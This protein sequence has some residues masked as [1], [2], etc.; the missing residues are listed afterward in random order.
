MDGNVKDCGAPA[1][2]R[3]RRSHHKDQ[4]PAFC[5]CAKCKGIVKQ[6]PRTI[7]NHQ[8]RYPRRTPTPERIGSPAVLDQFEGDN[9][10]DNDRSLPRLNPLQLPLS[11]PQSPSRSDQS[12]GSP[13]E[14]LTHENMV[15]PV[16]RQPARVVTPI[17]AGEGMEQQ[18]PEIEAEE[19]RIYQF[20]NLFN[21]KPLN[22]NHLHAHEIVLD[23]RIMYNDQEEM[24]DHI[25][26]DYE[27]F[28]EDF[29]L[30][31]GGDQPPINIAPAFQLPEEDEPEYAPD[32]DP[33]DP[34]N[35]GA[36][37]PAFQE[38]AAIRNAYIDAFIQKNLY[39][40]T[41]RALKHQ[42][43]AIRRTVSSHPDVNIED[44]SRMAQSIGTVE[45]RLG[46]DTDNIIITFVLCPTCKRR[47]SQEYIKETDVNTCVN[48]GCEGV[49][50]TT[51]RLASGSL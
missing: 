16:P 49:L 51:R 29:G 22:Q 24:G 31:E 9:A 25:E 10:V 21:D 18:E 4:L 42:L 34:D 20:D 40:A 47:Y 30:P 1:P 23:D 39:G 26:L 44:I 45:R 19:P 7:D 35:F 38:P 14:N 50:F 27:D 8:T 46:V 43:K 5:H 11:H 12:I 32:E 33:D 6:T 28:D 17:D 37:Y 36:H 41:H 15:Q 13:R 2:K 48:E 3:V